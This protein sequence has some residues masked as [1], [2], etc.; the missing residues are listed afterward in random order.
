MKLGS[1][2]MPL[3]TFV[4]WPGIRSSLLDV[5]PPDPVP[6]FGTLGAAESAMTLRAHRPETSLA[7]IVFTDSLGEQTVLGPRAPTEN[8]THASLM[9]LGPGPGKPAPQE[10]A[11]WGEK[12]ATACTQLFAP[13]G[14]PSLQELPLGG[15]LDKLKK[16]PQWELP[17]VEISLSSE[18]RPW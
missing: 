6:N 5:A 11:H 15:S 16:V 12:R 1:S 2:H 8:L 7:Q 9:L 18:Y 14:Q 10:G 13:P 17:Q 3:P 4:P